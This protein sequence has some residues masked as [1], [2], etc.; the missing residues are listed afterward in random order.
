[1]D[2]QSIKSV[3]KYAIAGNGISASEAEA[4]RNT[5]M[6]DSNK[7]R[8]NLLVELLGLDSESSLAEQ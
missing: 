1:M 7:E 3:V 5:V 6:L 8:A 4:V 2:F